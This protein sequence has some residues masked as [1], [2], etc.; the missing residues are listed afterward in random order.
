[1]DLDVFDL[2]ALPTLRPLGDV[3]LEFF[4]DKL[5]DLLT[6]DVGPQ[7]TLLE[8]VEQ[9]WPILLPDQ[10]FVKNWHIE[11][12]CDHLQAVT[13]GEIQNLL[14]NIP[15]GCMKSMLTSVFWPAWEW[16]RKPSL[17]YLCASYDQQLSTR[18]NLAVRQIIES[19]WYQARWPH[20]QMADDQN[21]KTRFNTT[22]GGWRIGTSVGGR[23]TGEH[24]HRK[25]VDDPHNVKKAESAP[26]RKGVITW[27]DRTLANRGLALGAATIVIMQR[28]HESDLSGHILETQRARWV[29]LCLPWRYESKRHCM[30][31]GSVKAHVEKDEVIFSEPQ[32]W[33][34]ER[35]KD[36][37]PLWPSLFPEADIKA[38]TG[39]DPYLDAGQYQQR[40]AP[41]G[42]GLFKLEWFPIVDAI[43]ADAQIIGR[44]RGWDSAATEGGGDWTVGALV[45]LARDGIVYV[46]DI[47][48]RQ[49][50][51][52]ADEVLMKQTAQL[53]G[54]KVEIREEQEP[55]S[56]GKKVIASHAKVLV[57][58]VYHGEPS[59]GDKTTRAKPFAAQAS[60]GNV[61]LVRGDWN[62]A[63]LDELSLFP[64]GSHDDQVD[65]TS[66]AF[67]HVALGRKTVKVRKLSGH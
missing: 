41:E 56:A 21:Q 35:R 53:D 59:T 6:V 7:L 14:I 18:D 67:N 58:Y 25:I 4:A 31:V 44:C 19:E 24:P 17:R 2:P 15:P 5:E 36:G 46:C 55:G 47:V 27:F 10:P 23:A 51:P 38:L 54:R 37:D 8:F 9:A 60:V 33:E 16:T 22:R 20:V 50:G 32:V 13:I 40:P 29:H 39:S 43:P 30:T 64:N 11:A 49:V 62:K 61:R 63:Y 57:G 45:A 3:A 65:A 12:I 42:G 48:R 52:G 26:Q 28:L 66:T 34:D 1:M